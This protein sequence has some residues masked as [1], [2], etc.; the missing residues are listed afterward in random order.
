M[1]QERSADSCKI[2]EMKFSGGYTA[3]P[4]PDPT[5]FLAPGSGTPTLSPHTEPEPF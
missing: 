5:T 4:V 3:L 2:P 1:G